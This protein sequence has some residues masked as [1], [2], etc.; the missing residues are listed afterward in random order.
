MNSHSIESSLSTLTEMIKMRERYWLVMGRLVFIGALAW[1]ANV[2]FHVFG[3]PEVRWGHKVFDS[4]DHP[5]SFTASR[6]HNLYTWLVIMPFV[7]HVMIV[8]TLQL[9][10]AMRTAF[11]ESALKYDLLNPDERGGFGFVDN[12]HIAFNVVAALVYVQITLHIETFERMNAEHIIGYSILTL[13]L[14][15]TNWIFLGDIYGK[16]K[17]LRFESLNELKDRVFDDKL[18]FEVLKYCLE[19]KTRLVSVEAVAIKAAG[20]VIPAVIKLW[21]K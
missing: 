15:G 7:G 19:Q 3:N 20:I 2:A 12:A 4:I 9:R 18:N 17:A 10:R 14:I 16:I 21:L 13:M 11:W 6:L 1:L 5:L 8:T